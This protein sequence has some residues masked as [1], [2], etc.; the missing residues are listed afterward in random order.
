MDQYEIFKKNINELIGIDLNLYKE[1]QMLRRI[2]SLMRRN[3]FSDFIEYYNKLK[4][5][6]E[7]LDQFVNYLTINVSEFFR[8]ISQWKVLE[9]DILPNLIKSANKKSLSVWS[10]ACSTGEEAY[11]LAMLFT[12]FYNLDKIKIL[13]TDIDVS[14]LNKARE[15]V[16]DEKALKNVPKE[17]VVKFFKK[18]KNQYRIKDEIKKTVDFRK[19]DLLKDPF[20]QNIDL[21]LC[22]NVMIYF[23]NEA[24]DLLYK[25][26]YNSLSDYGVLFVGSTEQILL[27]EKYNLKPIKTFF[28]TKI[29]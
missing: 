28:Y 4:V 13:A 20:P 22:R 21:I 15:G 23:T 25:K 24:K 5:D 1:K 17:F 12:K 7:L 29:K 9:E 10:S 3:G 8:N 19:I 18:N 26:F 27:P 11:S 6:K 2:T 14:A 16:Y